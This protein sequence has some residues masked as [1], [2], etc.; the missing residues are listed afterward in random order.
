MTGEVL[1]IGASYTFDDCSTCEGGKS[2]GSDGEFEDHGV[3]VKRSMQA[4]LEE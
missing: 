2:N 3:R 1:A 4:R